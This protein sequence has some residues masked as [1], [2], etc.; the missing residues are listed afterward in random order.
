RSV[1]AT[2]REH[3]GT[4]RRPVDRDLNPLSFAASA[5]LHGCALAAF[6]VMLGG[7]SGSDR[8]T[9]IPVELSSGTVESR[10]LALSRV[11][12]AKSASGHS[13]EPRI[14]VRR[15]AAPPSDPTA[16]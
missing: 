14:T 10:P 5:I 15:A 9:I 8:L 11:P 16:E 4:R 1:R 12:T 13:R 3:R 6:T 7:P 2:L